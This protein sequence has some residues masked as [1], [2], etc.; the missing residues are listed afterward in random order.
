MSTKG[1]TMKL[2]TE[3]MHAI[4]KYFVHDGEPLLLVTDNKGV[5]ESTN[6]SMR[7]L[8][9]DDII[10]L[11]FNDIIIDF[12]NAFSFD[13]CLD[14]G[15][16]KQMFSLIVPD[17]SPRTYFFSFLTVGSKV[18]IVGEVDSLELELLKEK[19]LAINNDLNSMT[20]EL[21]KKNSDLQQAL[22]EIST[23][24]GIIPICSYCKE[25]RDDKGLWNR[26]EEYIESHSEAQFSHSICEKCLDEHFP[27]ED[28]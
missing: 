17:G 22:D 4:I 6:T 10:G 7:N 26:L 27:E 14:N 18:V 25:I 20:R 13:K 8:L 16:Q 15:Q 11:P 19:L 5:I 1:N 24:Q 21:H 23:L 2:A 3:Q 12:H 9:R 28:D